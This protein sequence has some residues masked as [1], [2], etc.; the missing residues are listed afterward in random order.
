MASPQPHRHLPSQALVLAW[1]W[2]GILGGSA[3][4][5]AQAQVTESP[6]ASRTAPAFSAEMQQAMEWLEVQE[7]SRAE[8]LISTQLERNPRSPVWRF[9]QACLLAER[10]QDAQAIRSLEEFA[11]EFPELAEPHNN[12]AVLYLRNGRPQSARE[13]L[14]RALLNRPGYAL[15]HENLGDLY[16]LLA[17]QSYMAG[18]KARQPSA[19]MRAK[20]QH[21]QKL[22]RAAPLRLTPRLSLTERTVP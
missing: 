7:L 5:C 18:L 19:L 8:T 12:L 9:L 15:A 14:E 10:G 2:V 3:I 13:A 22:P 6:L 1:F 11:G 20:E 21:L 4:P 17:Q 16:A